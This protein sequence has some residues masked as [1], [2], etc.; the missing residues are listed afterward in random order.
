MN[1]IM[2][3]KGGSSAL[4]KLG[5]IGRKDDEFIRVHKETETHYI[6]MFEEGLGFIDVEFR[7]EDC[8]YLTEEERKELNG[9]WYGINGFPLY[10]IYVDEEGNV[11]K[12]KCAMKKGYIKTVTDNNGFP[13]HPSFGGLQIEFPEDIEIG[14]SL[15]M[16]AENGTITTSAVINVEIKNNI[17]LIYTKNS[18]YCVE[19]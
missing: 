10:K 13:K 5:N 1:K 15:I 19:I 14:K 2:I 11:I 16:F 7:K 3:L 6:G 18:I 4:H 17:Y 9:K 8:R 12:G